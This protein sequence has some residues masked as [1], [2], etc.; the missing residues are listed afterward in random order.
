MII[1]TGANGHLGQE[2]IAA[3]LQRTSGEQIVL[4]ARNPENLEQHK[5][6]VSDIRRA[7]Y[8]DPDS[9]CRRSRVLRPWC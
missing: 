8:D 1:L 5:T 2:I 7:D 4:S 9:L 6:R 3:L